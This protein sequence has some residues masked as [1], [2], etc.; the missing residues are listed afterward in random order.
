MP[1]SRLTAALVAAPLCAA[2]GAMAV[3]FRRAR[4]AQL[5]AERAAE[6]AALEI[7]RLGGGLRALC[8]SRSRPPQLRLPPPPHRLVRTPAWA[9]CT[10]ALASSLAGYSRAAQPRQPRQA[11]PAAI[12][13]SAYNLSR[14]GGAFKARACAM[15]ARHMLEALPE[16]AAQMAADRRLVLLLLDA[17]DCG[18]TRALA[19]ALPALRGLGLQ[20][21]IPQADPAHYA[22]MVAP[23]PSC[24][25]PEGGAGTP[26]EGEGAAE[27]SCTEGMLL[28]IRSQRLDE[29]LCT[30]ANKSLRVPIFFADYETSV[31]GRENV[32]LSP[33]TDVQRFL[34]FGFAHSRCLLAITLSYR[35]PHICRYDPD[36]PQLTP[37]DVAGF[38]AAEAAAQGFNCK[39]LETFPYGMTFSL[40]LLTADE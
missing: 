32:C 29:W 27:G 9:R 19:E 14:A 33:L 38:V 31:Y 34:R 17:P 21:C 40:F 10:Q 16:L 1:S 39:V 13:V 23:P 30:N 5:H 22:A 2:I 18:T 12:L 26:A 15:L 6:H 28:N 36:A 24:G 8:R 20:I 4:Q 35:V 25:A 37:E 11:E 7:A 3:L